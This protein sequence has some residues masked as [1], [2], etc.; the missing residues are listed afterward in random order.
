MDE[1]N[2]Y[3]LFSKKRL[4]STKRLLEGEGVCIENKFSQPYTGFVRCY[5]ILTCNSLPY[6]FNPPINS[7][8]GFDHACFE[9]EKRAMTGRCRV[10]E[11]KKSYNNEKDK[12]PFTVTE[13]AHIMKFMSINIDIFEPYS[14][15]Y[16][17]FEISP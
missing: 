4:P 7:T 3:Q 17:L 15:A 10:T 14:P 8:S 11:L 13:L 1:A 5:T 12:F 9:R 16:D 6:P 2:V